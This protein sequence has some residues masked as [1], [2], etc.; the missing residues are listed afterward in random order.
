MSQVFNS[1]PVLLEEAKDSEAN[2]PEEQN[3]DYDRNC[4]REYEK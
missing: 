1:A 4:E 3:D 2:N